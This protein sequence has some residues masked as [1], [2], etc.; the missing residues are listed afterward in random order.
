MFGRYEYDAI[1]VIALG[2]K[3]IYRTSVVLAFRQNVF[4]NGVFGLVVF[5]IVSYSIHC[6]TRRRKTCSAKLGII[7]RG[8][9]LQ[10]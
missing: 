4:Q 7:A 10:D 3:Y 5:V 2:L 8:V 6:W 1:I 9:C